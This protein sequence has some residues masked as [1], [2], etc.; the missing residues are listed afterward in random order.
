VRLTADLQRSRERLVL[1]REEERR[2][3]RRDLH[4]DLGP[5]LASLGLAASTVADLIPK[6]PTAATKLVKELESQMRATVGNVR[7]LVYDLRPP[8]LDELGL[9]PA[10]RERA[11]DIRMRLKGFALR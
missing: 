6:N 8:T 7:R 9:L 11:L 1:A 10:V 2:R 5:T 3:L 4:D